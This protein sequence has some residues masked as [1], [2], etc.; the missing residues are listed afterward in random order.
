MATSNCSRSDNYVD[1]CTVKASTIAILDDEPDRIAA[2]RTALAKDSL[3][4]SVVTFENAPDTIAWLRDH[5][6]EVV[7][8]CLDHDLG[9]NR[10]RGDEVFDPG[11]GRDVAD[12]LATRSPVCPVLIHTTNSM[13]APGMVRVLE[14]VGWSVSR[15]IPYDDL[16]WIG[17]DWSEEVSRLLESR[18]T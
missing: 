18:E 15:V 1:D 4:H 6:S 12:Y 14:E 16:A 10:R 17:L 2:M 3:R 9:P 8:I 11:I 13:A 5:L 7:L